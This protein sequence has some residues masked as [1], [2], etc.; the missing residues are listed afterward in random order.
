MLNKSKHLLYDIIFNS[1]ITLNVQYF[2]ISIARLSPEKLYTYFKEIFLRIDILL[3]FLGYA[4]LTK[5]PRSIVTISLKL[6]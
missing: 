2:R 4:T 3:A 5:L 6:T 1:Y